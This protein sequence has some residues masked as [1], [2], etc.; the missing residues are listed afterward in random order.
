MAPGW[1]DV[2]QAALM[3]AWEKTNDESGKSDDIYRH[4]LD[5]CELEPPKSK[6]VV[7]LRKQTLVNMCR[8]IV[9]IVSLKPD[10]GGEAAIN[11]ERE[12]EQVRVWFRLSLKKRKEAFEHANTSSY[13][14]V[15][16]DETTFWSVQRRT[17]GVHMIK[18]APRHDWDRDELFALLQAHKH[19]LNEPPRRRQCSVES[20][21]YRRFVSRCAGEVKRSL[22]AT[23]TKLAAM[24][25]MISVIKGHNEASR[26]SCT[27]CYAKNNWF[28]LSPA[29]RKASF[30]ERNSSP[31]RFLD[32]D[33]TLFNAAERAV[34]QDSQ[35]AEQPSQ[36][37]QPRDGGDPAATAATVL[38]SRSCCEESETESVETRTVRKSMCCG[39]WLG[40]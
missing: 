38:S 25:N 32:L 16:V 24:L 10:S 34:N 19:A 20:L 6:S 29:E 28:A 18:S 23:A 5:L 8:L 26:D 31:H 9:S 27:A 12:R 3:S 33:E 17:A 37:E 2:E 1:S 11:S 35:V 36:S 21:T 4:F 30:D 15:D 13:G 7:I 39:N 14:F 40:L 22:Q